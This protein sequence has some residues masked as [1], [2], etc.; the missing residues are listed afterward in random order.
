MP[1]SIHIDK[2]LN[3]EEE[4]FDDILKELFIENIVNSKQELDSKYRFNKKLYEAIEYTVKKLKKEEGFMS[5]FLY[6]S[7]GIGKKKNRRRRYLIVLGRQLKRE[8]NKVEKNIERVTF[9][10]KNSVISSVALGRLSKS[11][12]KKTYTLDDE[13]V[14]DRCNR[15]LKKIYLLTDRVERYKKDLDLKSIF[16]EDSLDKYEILLKQ[17]PRYH[18]L[19]DETHLLE[20]NRTHPR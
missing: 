17:I 12:G 8:I 7:F 18:E 15:Y 6:S 4:V 9:C 16:L 13:V 2:L 5:R 14:A 3:S 19:R 10:Y 20:T 11:F 1:L